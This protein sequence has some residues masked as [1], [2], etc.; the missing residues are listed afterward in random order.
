MCNLQ[1]I[2]VSILFQGMVKKIPLANADISE[3]NVDKKT[4]AFK[5]K[6]KENGRAYFLHTENKESLH[7]WMQGICFAKA[8][9]KN[10]S[11]SAACV[12]Q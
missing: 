3:S 1:L 8:A 9:G 6:S 10:N 2:I 4:N 5:I 12:L 11:N 7:S